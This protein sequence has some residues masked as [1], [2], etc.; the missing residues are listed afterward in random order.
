MM[1]AGDTAFI[2]I[3]TC[4]V[5][6]MTPAVAVLYGSLT[7]RRYGPTMLMQT[8]I[9]IPVITIVWSLLGFTL[10]FGSD[11]L[12]GLIG[13]LDYLFLRNIGIETGAFAPT[14]SFALFFVFQATFAIITSALIC[15]AVVGRMRLLPYMLFISLWSL[16]VYSPVVHWVWGGGILQQWGYVDFAGGVPVHMIA[17]FSALAAVKAVGNRETGKEGPSNLTNVVIAMG[18]LWAGWF[19]FNGGSSMAAGGTAAVAMVSTLLGSSAGAIVWM[20]LAYYRNDKQVTILD[21]SFGALAGLIVSSPLAGYVVP[22]VIILAG[23]IAG[24]ACYYAVL[25]RIQ[26]NY[27]DTLDVWALH[28]VGGLLGAFLLGIFADPS[29][30][31][32]AGLLYGNP[33]QLTVQAA[34]ILIA[35]VYCFIVTYVMVK[36]INR[37]SRFRTAGDVPE[38]FGA[39]EDTAVMNG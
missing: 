25:F 27:D 19:C 23:A 33:Q 9:A 30:A 2:L 4:V 37:F 15:G 38:D 22:W 3:C 18:I 29:L 34:G 6:F 13:G 21:L 10:A 20:M 1:Q 12:G 24:L 8:C 7:E 36:V 31:P 26:H 14:V 11:V 35:A 5:L 28:G 32:A 17:G 39:E 16:L